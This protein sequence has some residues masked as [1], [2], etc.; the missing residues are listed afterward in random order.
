MKAINEMT[1]QECLEEMRSFTQRY[2]NCVLAKYDEP[3][4]ELD[5]LS[6][7]I[8]ELTR[9]I[10]VEERMPDNGET[11]L[12]RRVEGGMFGSKEIKPQVGTFRNG[13]FDCVFGW[14]RVTHWRRNDT[15]QGV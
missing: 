8:T 5:E 3:T 9:W 13:S 2:E 1:L 10:P 14:T 12:C 4:Q 15:P 11:V 7:R 6:N